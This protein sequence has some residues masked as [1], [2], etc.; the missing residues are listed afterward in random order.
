MNFDDTPQE[1]EFRAEA[2]AFLDANATL[3][4]ETELRKET[5]EEY[6]ERALAWQKL[7]AENDELRKRVAALER[8]E[9]R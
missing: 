1:A 2:R 7:K 3:K 9:L 6:I 5:E 4:G 8:R